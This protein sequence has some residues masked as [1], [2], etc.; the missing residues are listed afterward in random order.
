MEFYAIHLQ[1]DS[2]RC[3]RLNVNDYKKTCIFKKNLTFNTLIHWFTHVN[4]YI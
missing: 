3:C 4:D 1:K 2:H